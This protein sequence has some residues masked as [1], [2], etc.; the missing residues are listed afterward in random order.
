MAGSGF[1]SAFVSKQAAAK[2]PAAWLSIRYKMLRQQ[3]NSP[4]RAA[5][6]IAFC[7]LRCHARPIPRAREGM[8]S[9]RSTCGRT[10]EDRCIS[11][12]LHVSGQ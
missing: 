1:G 2:A 9:Y 11:P 12:S 7:G 10:R 5:I 3:G 4:L 8:H 6:M